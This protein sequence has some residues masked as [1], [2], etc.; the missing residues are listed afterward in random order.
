MFIRLCYSKLDGHCLGLFCICNNFF[1]NK[2]QS[3]WPYYSS[4]QSH[5]SA[6]LFLVNSV[7]DL[8]PVVV[9]VSLGNYHQ[10][11]D[12]HECKECT[13]TIWWVPVPSRYYGKLLFQIPLKLPHTSLHIL[14]SGYKIVNLSV[15]RVVQKEGSVL[16]SGGYYNLQQLRHFYKYE[17]DTDELNH[18]CNFIYVSV[19]L[20]RFNVKLIHKRTNCKQKTF[21][22]NKAMDYVRDV[23]SFRSISSYNCY[24]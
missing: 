17:Y 5:L 11:A 2:N 18:K 22:R 1:Y 20:M 8:F 19:I 24:I 9:R 6:N 16:A 10:I 15:F 14:I 13:G 23:L 7:R 4:L 3:Q 12:L 21:T